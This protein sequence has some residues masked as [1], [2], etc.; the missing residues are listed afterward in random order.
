MRELIFKN[1]NVGIFRNSNFEII[2]IFKDLHPNYSEE[3]LA[4]WLGKGGIPGS[5]LHHKKHDEIPLSKSVGI[6]RKFK[7]VIMPR[8][9]EINGIKN[10]EYTMYKISL[11]SNFLKI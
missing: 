9:K 10:R 4:W 2:I 11:F 3:M 6:E 1:Y 5:Y 8:L 7:D